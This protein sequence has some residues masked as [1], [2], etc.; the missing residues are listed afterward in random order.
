VY[1]TS[2]T[3]DSPLIAAH[4]DLL[5][6][7]AWI[8]LGAFW[9]AAMAFSKRAAQAQSLGA[10]TLHLV[11]VLPG[12]LLLVDSNLAIGWLGERFVPAAP[13]VLIA[14]LA[15]T[16]AGCLFAAWARVTLGSNWSGRVEL[17]QN[18]KLV[19]SG[20]YALARHPIY[21]GLIV[22]AAGTALAIGEWRCAIGIVLV[23]VAFVTKIR[24]EEP[25]MLQAFPDEYPAYR[26]RVKAL[27]PGLI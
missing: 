14:G 17:K 21:T 6:L 13:A 11:I 8:A 7:Y 5:I 25:V 20:P 22:A 4:I 9:L 23:V 18:H 3:T 27:I 19:T 15:I 12:Y 1:D 2:Y 10:R 16:I 26:R 24:Q